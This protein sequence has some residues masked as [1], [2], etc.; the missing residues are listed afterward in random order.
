MILNRIR[1]PPLTKAQKEAEKKRIEAEKKRIEVTAQLA[2]TEKK[3]NELK[4][5]ISQQARSLTPDQKKEIVKQFMWWKPEESCSL[6][7]KTETVLNA[8]LKVIKNSLS[9]IVEKNNGVLQSA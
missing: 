3:I 8:L 7:L 5:N 1:N 9:R 6:D 4:N 2:E